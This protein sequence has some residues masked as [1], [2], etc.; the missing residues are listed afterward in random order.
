V[1]Q[2]SG[3]LPPSP[4]TVKSDPL[5]SL[6]E[7]CLDFGDWP[8]SAQRRWTLSHTSGAVKFPPLSSAATRSLDFVQVQGSE[9][10]GRPWHN[11]GESYH[12]PLGLSNPCHRALT[13]L[14]QFGFV[15]CSPVHGATRGEFTTP[16]WGCQIRTVVLSRSC[17]VSILS[18]ARPSTAQ[19]RATVP[20]SPGPVKPGWGCS[21]IPYALTVIGRKAFPDSGQG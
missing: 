15:R 9:A 12:T 21:L 7:R 18:G 10:L 13:I 20:L 16:R 4:R 6:E 2:R 8:S 17:G 11:D 1:A 5:H 19:R 3:S 14:R